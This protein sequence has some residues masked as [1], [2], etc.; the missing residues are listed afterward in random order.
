M[1]TNGDGDAEDDEEPL[2]KAFLGVSLQL[3]SPSKV[4]SQLDWC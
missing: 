2:E 4:G 3:H 1:S